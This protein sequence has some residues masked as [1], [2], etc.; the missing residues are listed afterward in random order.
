M[1]MKTYL[2]SYCEME[3]DGELNGTTTYVLATSKVEAL[4]AVI[5]MFTTA[6]YSVTSVERVKG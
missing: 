4:M 2:V 1:T 6:V 3:S 5:N